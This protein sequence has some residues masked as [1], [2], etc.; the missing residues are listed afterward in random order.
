[1]DNSS[2]IRF[3]S[4]IEVNSNGCWIWTGTKNKGYGKF[5]YKGQK[6]LAHR[7]SYWHFVDSEYEGGLDHFECDNPSCVHPLH[8]RPA[9]QR[10]NLL[11][12][13]TV[14]SAHA[15]KTHCDY[16]H[17]FTKQNTRISVYKGNV[18]R[19]CKKCDARRARKYRKKKAAS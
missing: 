5:W 17:K 19:K 4:K 9:S 2:L 14:S 13:N 1:M 18:S 6:R 7:V 15:A 12:G 8:V 16:G 11:R 10:E 3:I